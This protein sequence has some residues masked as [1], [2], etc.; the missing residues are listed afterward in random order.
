MSTDIKS[1]FHEWCA[2]NKIGD[3]TFEV[4]PTG[5]LNIDFFFVGVF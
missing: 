5:N 4:R 2:K 3:P 1:F